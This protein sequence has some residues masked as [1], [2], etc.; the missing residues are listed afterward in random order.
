MPSEICAND[1]NWQQRCRRD[2]YSENT[3]CQCP[4]FKLLGFA[5]QSPKRFRAHS[6]NCLFWGRLLPLFCL[7]IFRLY[8]SP[9]LAFYLSF[10]CPLCWYPPPL[11]P[12]FC[13]N[14]FFS[15]YLRRPCFHPPRRMFHCTRRLLV[16]LL[17]HDVPRLLPRRRPLF[18][19]ESSL[20]VAHDVHG[21]CS[22]YW[23][24]LC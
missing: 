10:S 1:I 2:C 8:L 19:Q 24:C 22:R 3:G 11:S 12:P 17:P 21:V 13:S 6:G 14:F 5:R 23:H 15:D 7:S 4:H 20:G 18:W 16:P 9:V